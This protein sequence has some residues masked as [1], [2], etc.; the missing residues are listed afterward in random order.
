MNWYKQ[1]KVNY[2]LE[3][4]PMYGHS[5]YK[6]HGG[7][8]VQMSPE[9]FLQ[10]TGRPLDIDES[11]QENIDELK[12][13]MQSGR[14]IDPPTLYFENKVIIEHDGRHRAHA[15]KQLGIT[16]IPVLVMEQ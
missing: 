2:P 11:S 7:K 6:T 13:M 3:D 9:E 4:P 15:A 14:T 5:D 1:A 16:S 12:N 8:I 10:K